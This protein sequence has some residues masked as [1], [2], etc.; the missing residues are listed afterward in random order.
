MALDHKGD[1][2][3][4]IVK[5]LMAL[6]HKGDCSHEI[7]KDL[8]AL[9]HKGDCSR[10]IVKDLM[11]LDHKGDCS[12]EIVKDLMALDHKGDCSREILKDLMALDHKCGCSH[13]IVKDLMALDHKCGCSHEIVKDLM[14][15]LASNFL[16]KNL[17]ILK[18]LVSL[19]CNCIKAIGLSRKKRFRNSITVSLKII[20][21]HGICFLKISIGKFDF[22][23]FGLKDGFLITDI[24]SHRINICTESLPIEAFYRMHGSCIVIHTCTCTCMSGNIL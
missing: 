1:C 6:D 21:F 11:A 2:P 17:V 14:A 13:E 7:V 9:D 15:W 3:R 16:L 24:E 18:K 5:D 22:K 4:E 12:H 23:M 19:N 8:M 20:F 10:E